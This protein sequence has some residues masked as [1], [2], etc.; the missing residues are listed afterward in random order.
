LCA[1]EKQSMEVEVKGEDGSELA[2]VNDE[3]TVFGRGCGFSTDDRTVS[4]RHVS[5]KL[6]HSDSDVGDANARVS[7]EVMGKNPFWVY[8]G[9]ALRVFRKFEKGY[10]QPGDRFCFSPNSPLWYS[11]TLSNKQPHPQLNLDEIDISEIDPVKGITAF[12]CS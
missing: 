7:F 4:R 3:K 5:F 12:P 1:E 11:F 10:L 8:D 2:L 6:H 9:E